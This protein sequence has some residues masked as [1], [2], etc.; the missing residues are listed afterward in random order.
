[1]NPE[2]RA[3][4]F[5][6]EPA[7]MR[8]DRIRARFRFVAT[9]LAIPAIV[10]LCLEHG[11]DEPPATVG[12]LHLIQ[13]LAVVAYVVSVGA[14]VF[15]SSSWLRGVRLYWFEVLFITV[16]A[17]LLIGA[18]ELERAHM[19]SW[20]LGYVIVVQ[21]LLVGRVIVGAVRLNLQLSRKTLSPARLLLGAFLTVIFAGGMLLSL[22]R[23][24]R[25]EVR[26]HQTPSARMVNSLFT[27]VSATCVTG[28]VVY[29]T[30]HDFSMFGQVVILVLIQLGGLGIMIFSTVFSLLAGMHLSLRQSLVLQDELSHRTIGQM[31]GMVRFILIVTFGFELL[32]AISLYPAYANIA[33]STGGAMFQAVFHSISAFCN[34]GFA[35]QSD[36]LIPF[37]GS[38]SLYTTVM[39]LIVL[40][41]LGFPV[42]KDLIVA[43]Q[44]RFTKSIEPPASL[45]APLWRTRRRG[46]RHVLSL[47]SRLALITSAILIV[48]PTILFTA[49]ESREMQSDATARSRGDAPAIVLTQTPPHSDEAKTATMREL[50]IAER[51]DAAL[52]L[53][54]T[55]RTAGFN[56]VRMD[57]QS[58]SPASH[59]LL[60]VLMFIGGSP[61]STAGGIKTVTL[62]ILVLS[63]WRTLRGRVRVE[64]FHR[65]LDESIVARAAAL[66]VVMFLLVTLIVLLLSFTENTSV[67][68]ALFETVSALGTVGLSTG[69][70]ERLTVAGRVI[71][72]LAM[73]AGRLGPL[74]L[75]IALAGKTSGARYEY[76]VESVA[77]G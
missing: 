10:S 55:A 62:A 19:L 37:R 64:A 34:A 27:A 67:R 59:F 42:I 70:T 49:F 17:A 29:D 20:S 75:L 25:P 4:F 16:G 6:H 52:F 43:I 45:N 40:G 13:A 21:A 36:S 24:V 7:M 58:L 48:F 39:P 77:I 38:W 44:S 30:G 68:E 65:E 1:M 57:E 72:M 8:V 26:V 3:K 2:T 76:P 51:L 28:L 23:A 5:G 15:T 63:V 11:F 33:T 22:P 56:T 31:G 54:V 41:G 9:L 12:W 61:G 46:R 74:T 35:L 32:G 69:L 73:L 53:S 66:I 14:C 71:I 47:H 50:P 18:V 60:A